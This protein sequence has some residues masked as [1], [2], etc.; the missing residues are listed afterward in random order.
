[1]AGDPPPRR[2]QPSLQEDGEDLEDNAEAQ[3]WLES[4]LDGLR[5]DDFGGGLRIFCT[6]HLR[7][8]EAF[9]DV[10]HVVSADTD[11]HADTLS[12]TAEDAAQLNCILVFCNQNKSHE[13]SRLGQIIASIDVSGFDAPPMFWVPHSAAPE[14]RRHENSNMV[15]PD[16][17]A[18]LLQQG[19]DGVVGVGE[20]RGLRLS[21]AVLSNMRK[22]QRL[23][24]NLVDMLEE[25]RERSQYAQ[26]LRRCAHEALWNY[27]RARLAPGIPPVD[28]TLEA[29]DMDS[30]E[31]P[32]F[33]IGNKLGEG[34]F[35]SVYRLTENPGTGTQVLKM[36]QTEGVTDLKD[37]M[38]IHSM[39]EAMRKMSEG[40]LRHPNIIQFFQVYN[41]PTHILFRLEYGGPENLYRRLYGR[42]VQQPERHRPLPSDK[43]A[44]I[45]SQAV[46]AVCHL[47]TRVRICL[48]DIKPENIILNETPDDVTVKLADF[49]LCAFIEDDDTVFHRACGTL[50]FSAPEV[51]MEIP[52]DGRKADIWSLGV[53]VAE[54]LCG[55][56]VVEAQIQ[57]SGL[58]ERP[59]GAEAMLPERI[60][61][62]FQAPGAAATL[63]EQH[64]RPELQSL[65]AC[66]ST[67]I[68][69]MLQVD[70]AQR[71]TAEE[72]RSQVE[73]SLRPF[74]ARPLAPAGPA[75]SH[76]RPSACAGR[77][78]TASQPMSRQ[79]SEPVRPSKAAA[80]LD[81]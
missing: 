7:P 79:L 9:R 20:P 55:I 1:M 72:V 59:G 53:V 8:P 11:V 65:V 42:Q 67:T 40:E 23:S 3:A 37:L 16:V 50:P 66:C 56:R 28:N 13:V 70:P 10:W 2:R 75:P 81:D 47:H 38:Y 46:E 22:S 14:K 60:K 63:L 71:W 36:V 33:T 77:S 5:E 61:A 32:G 80:R 29:G 51:M 4:R 17:A 45:I 57:A 43:A 31:L 27:T 68:A 52:Y 54:V 12:L 76:R 73:Q 18:H 58:Q 69:G 30:L 64:G 34:V 15:Q 39:T 74:L 78:Q 62:F 44:K 25:S 26:H 6:T 35:G 24:R 48:L 41:T 19:L 49:D 21:M